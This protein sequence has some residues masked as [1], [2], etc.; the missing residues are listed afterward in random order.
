MGEGPLNSF[1]VSLP[2]LKNIIHFFDFHVFSCKNTTRVFFREDNN[3]EL[4][5][6][7]A[8]QIFSVGLNFV[9]LLPIE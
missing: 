9:F 8:N 2:M 7:Y 1:V 4:D 6:F 3:D 5:F